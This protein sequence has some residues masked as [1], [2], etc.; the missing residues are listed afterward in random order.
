MRYPAIR[1]QGLGNEM[2]FYQLKRR[3]FITLIGG[4]SAAWP[5]AAR[6]QQRARMR[7]VVFLHALAEHD[8]EVQARIVAFRQGLETLGWIENRN[9]HAEHSY[10]AGDLAQMQAHSWPFGAAGTAR[11]RRRGDRVIRRRS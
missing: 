2:R 6:A 1:S 8:P 4:A 3:Q 7:R 9:V 11:H 5:L 10:S